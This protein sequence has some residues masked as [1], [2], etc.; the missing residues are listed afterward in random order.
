MPNPLTL[1]LVNA[2]ENK[3]ELSEGSTFEENLE[4][5]KIDEKDLIILKELSKNS[6]IKNI[7]LAQK[8]KNKY[9]V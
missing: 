5:V 8:I 9:H 7:E 3:I 2:R 1:T 4:N 6:K